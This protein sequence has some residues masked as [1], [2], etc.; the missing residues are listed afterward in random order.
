M[1][2]KEIAMLVIDKLKD[3]QTPLKVEQ[4]YQQK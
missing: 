1:I 2:S 3:K 4:S